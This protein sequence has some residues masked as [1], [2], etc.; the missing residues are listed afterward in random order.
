MGWPY[1]FV[2]LDAAGQSSRRELLDRYGAYAQLSAFVPVLLYQ[3]NRLAWWVLSERQRAEP[4]YASV[5]RSPGSPI[6]KKYNS[7]PKGVF[8]TRWRAVVWWLQSDLVQGWGERGHWIAGGA[9]A[10]WLLFLSV[11][12][13]GV[14]MCTSFSS[15]CFAKES[16]NFFYFH[17]MCSMSFYDLHNIIHEI[18]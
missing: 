17:D 13:T 6:S 2:D 8:S 11:H 1:H 15:S 14:G 16:P 3:L 10:A 5:P 7:S 12:E 4:G 18:S 9:W